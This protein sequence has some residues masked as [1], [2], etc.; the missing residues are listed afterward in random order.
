MTMAIERERV[1]KLKK[2]QDT[3]NDEVIL[4]SDDPFTNLGMG[5]TGLEATGMGKAKKMIAKV[6]KPS[7]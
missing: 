6:E 4:E 1:F 3:T 2:M 5:D 7:L